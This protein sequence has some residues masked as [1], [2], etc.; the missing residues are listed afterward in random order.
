[1]LL[2]SAIRHDNK[3]ISSAW[4]D[5]RLSAYVLQLMCITTNRHEWNHNIIVYPISIPAIT[6]YSIS[7]TFYMIYTTQTYVSFCGAGC[8]ELN[9]RT[10]DEVMDR[11]SELLRQPVTVWKHLLRTTLFA[12]TADCRRPKRMKCPEHMPNV[13]A[14]IRMY[15]ANNSRKTATNTSTKSTLVT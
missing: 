14:I 12:S 2:L 11:N 1:M 3:T 5:Y 13:T 4:T 8:S 7:L 9:F 15:N 6:D 10:N